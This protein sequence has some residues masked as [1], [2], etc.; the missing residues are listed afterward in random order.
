[1]IGNLLRKQEDQ[2]HSKVGLKCAVPENKSRNSDTNAETLN[3]WLQKGR[4]SPPS[5][6]FNFPRNG[7]KNYL[8]QDWMERKGNKEWTEVYEGS[9]GRKDAP[10]PTVAGTRP[11]PGA[12]GWTCSP[13][14][15][16]LIT[17]KDAI[18][19]CESNGKCLKG[20]TYGGRTA[21]WHHRS[22]FREEAPREG[23]SECL[24]GRHSLRTRHCGQH[25]TL[26]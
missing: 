22:A 18:A 9:R 7:K 25:E 8:Q 14:C 10:G 26:C 13:A 15:T 4:E 5:V 6:C 16:L 21:F 12:W 24:S 3:T 1:M 20:A 11:P 23:H 19:I 17:I 2:G